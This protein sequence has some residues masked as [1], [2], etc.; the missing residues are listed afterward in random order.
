MAES[1]GLAFTIAIIVGLNGHIRL[2]DLVLRECLL[3]PIGQT[4]CKIDSSQSLSINYRILLFLIKKI[5]SIGL[6]RA[7]RNFGRGSGVSPSQSGKPSSFRRLFRWLS[8]GIFVKRW[9]LTIYVGVLMTL[10]GVAIWLKLTPIFWLFQAID[11]AVEFVARIV[12]HYLSGPVVLGCGLFLVFWGHSRSLG[13]IS[14]VLRPDGDQTLLDMLW[15]N[16]R[17]NRGP[18]IVAIGGGTGLSTLLRGLKLY[19]ANLTAIVTVADDGGSSGRL[20]RDFG[21]LPPGDIR[22][23]IAALADEEKLLTELFQYRFE[24]GDGLMGHSFGNLFLTAM[25]EITG[26]LERAVVAS[27]KVLAIRGRVLPATLTDVALW[28][29]LADGRI[30]EGESSIGSSDGQ[31]VEIGCTPANPPA[32]P[33]AIAAIQEADYII[34]GP[35]SLY[36]SVIS[37]LLVPEI[38]EAI[39]ARNVPRIYVCN[40]MT[41]PGETTGYT[42]ADHIESIDRA[43]GQKLFDAVLVQ[44][45]PPSA[46]CLQNYAEENSYPV[47]LDRE[48]VKQLGRSIFSVNVMEENTTTRYLRH[49][50]RRL[51]KSLIH[52]YRRAQESAPYRT[53]RVTPLDRNIK[54]A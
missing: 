40:I 35:G 18:K 16:R 49:N 42:V 3:F 24:A 20:R 15:Q 12:P 48:D 36:T 21:V 6:F 26:D 46:S 27:S 13:E 37:N 53:G 38:A 39:A 9:L 31:I 8:P 45:N 19:S 41:Q 33:A 54:S 43:C 7:V 44:K 28:A 52:Y 34:M 2:Y 51:A 17:L 32:L 23:C 14:K 25:S 4:T 11:K 10:L 50:S 29:K 22:N 30:I 1:S 47:L 5:M